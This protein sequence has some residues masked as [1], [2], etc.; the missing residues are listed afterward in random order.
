MTCDDFNKHS[1]IGSE[2]TFGT[3]HVFTD[4]RAFIHSDGNPRPVVNIK[5]IA[6]SKIRTIGIRFLKPVK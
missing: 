6:N 4:C 1:Q 5:P 2:F 3:T